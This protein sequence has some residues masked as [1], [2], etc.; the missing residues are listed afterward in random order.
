MF[1]KVAKIFKGNALKF[2]VVA[3]TAAIIAGCT[4]PPAPTSPILLKA[5]SEIITVSANSSIAEFIGDRC[6]GI[7]YNESYVDGL[8]D[9]MITKLEQDHDRGKFSDQELA[10]FAVGLRQYAFNPRLQAMSDR[11]I[12]QI[13]DQHNLDGMT[14]AELCAF[15]ENQRR[16]GTYMGKMFVRS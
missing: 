15:G 7:A 2:T 9:T 4:P 14:D 13:F 5:E 8:I 3:V 6:N 11:R 1:E 10:N 12:D 16:H